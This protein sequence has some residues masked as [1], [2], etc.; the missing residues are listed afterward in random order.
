MKFKILKLRKSIFNNLKAKAYSYEETSEELALYLADQVEASKRRFQLSSFEEL[1]HTVLGSRVIYLGDFHTFDQ[2]VRNVLRIVKH[3]ISKQ[4]QCVLGLEMVSSKHQ[5]YIDTYID[6][7]LTDLEFLECI[8]YSHS[9]RFPWTHYK[10]IFELAKKHKLKVLGLNTAGSLQTR[11]EYAAKL[12][13]K[14]LNSNSE[15]KMLVLYG[16]LHITYNKIPSILKSKIPDV[17]FTVIHQNLDEVYWKL[18]RESQ[19]QGIVK[20]TQEEYCI[21]SAP[22]WIKYESM[23]YWYENVS[24]DPDFDI[25]EYIIETGAKIFTEDTSENFLGISLEMIRHLQLGKIEE[26][27]ENF[28][29][30][31]HSNLEYIEQVLVDN[32]SLTLNRFY[33]KLITNN[34]SFRLPTSSTFYCSSYSMNRIAYLAGIHILHIYLEKNSI[35]SKDVLNSKSNNKKFMLFV[36]ESL[37]GYLFSK[38]INPHRKCEMYLDIQDSLT[39]LDSITYNMAYLFMNTNDSSQILK[40]KKVFQIYKCSQLIGHILGEYSYIKLNEKNSQINLNKFLRTI[41]LDKKSFLQTIEHIL[42][43]INYK[44]HRKRYF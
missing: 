23:I 28:N 3:I 31:D 5:L 19:E 18:I 24:D 2:N 30:Y 29:L 6:G 15:T 9:W 33:Q 41:S 44:T 11:D 35:F 32:V 27:I 13:S 10:L 42:E 4:S 36:Y 12:I 20:F 21:I 8:N 25:H 1:S 17:K 7:H 26:E 37:F 14:C 39:S 22:P 16:E 34:I 40:G 38:I 43:D